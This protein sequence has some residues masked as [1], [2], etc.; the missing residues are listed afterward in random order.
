M[1]N[2][3]WRPVKPKPPSKP[4]VADDVRIA[5]DTQAIPVVADLKKRF[6]F[7]MGYARS[8]MPRLWSDLWP[9]SKSHPD[10]QVGYHGE[11]LFGGLCLLLN[12]KMPFGVW[13]DS[14]IARFGPDQGDN[15]LQVGHCGQTDETTGLKQRRSSFEICRANEQDHAHDHMQTELN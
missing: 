9:F 5:I 11:K 13:K 3:T 12:G 7:E 4:K 2:R 8:S 1:R 10:Q 14:L 15:A 6:V